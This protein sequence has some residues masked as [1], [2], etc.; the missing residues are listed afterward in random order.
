MRPKITS[1]ALVAHSFPYPVYCIEK[2]SDVQIRCELPNLKVSCKMSV[3]NPSRCVL[4]MIFLFWITGCARD[5]ATSTSV[6]PPSTPSYTEANVDDNHASGI[7]LLYERS[8]G[9]AGIHDEWKAY[10]DG[11]FE[12]ND[13]TIETLNP[14]ELDGVLEELRKLGF[15]D[16]EMK[17][18]PFDS[19]ADCFSYRLLVNFEGQTN[20]ISWNEASTDTPVNFKEILTLINTLLMNFSN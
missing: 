14:Q 6:T 8:G 4:A 11:R 18:N 5:L 13:G 12:L 10:S 1:N 3:L 20:E 7:V 19:C 9:I 16:L 2:D 17:I 15:F